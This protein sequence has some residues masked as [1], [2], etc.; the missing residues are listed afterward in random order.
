[1]EGWKLQHEAAWI[2]FAALHG[3]LEKTKK[4]LP[5]ATEEQLNNSK[6]QT[7]LIHAV[8]GNHLD[9]V[10]ELLTCDKLDINAVDLNG[11]TALHWAASVAGNKNAVQ[12]LLDAGSDIHKASADGS[13][14]LLYACS[15]GQAAI[16]RL[17]VEHGA[18]L[19]DRA[20]DNEVG[21]HLACKRGH[22][23]VVRA[24][25]ELDPEQAIHHNASGVTPMHM[26]VRAD[27]PDIVEAILE[28]SPEFV[29]IT[30]CDPQPDCTPLLLSVVDGHPKVTQV[31]LKYQADCNITKG[32]ASALQMACANRNKELVSLLL[33]SADIDINLADNDGDTPLH[34]TT[35]AL[36]HALDG[37]SVLEIA[38][39][40]IAAGA[41]IKHT[42]LNGQVAFDLAPT[43]MV[44]LLQTAAEARERPRTLMK[45]VQSAEDLRKACEKGDLEAVEQ[46]LP[47][48]TAEEI[49]AGQLTSPLHTAVVCK[50]T[51]IVKALLESKKCNVDS[52]KAASKASALHMAVVAESTEIVKLL[53]EHG[54]SPGLKDENRLTPLHI[55]SHN[56][57]VNIVKLLLEQDKLDV[58]DVDSGESTALHRACAKGHAEVVSALLEAPHLETAS[59]DRL[60]FTPLQHAA[61]HASVDCI[62]ALLTNDY[63]KHAIDKPKPD[64]FTAL[65]LAAFNKC[66]EGCK[67]LLE[68]GAEIALTNNKGQT[69]LHLAVK[70][71]A[72][73]TADVLLQHCTPEV[74]NV[75]NHKGKTALHQ[76]VKLMHGGAVSQQ[77]LFLAAV[78]G[79]APTVSHSAAHLVRDLATKLVNGGASITASDMHEN[80]PLDICPDAAF[81]SELKQAAIEF[82]KAHPEVAATLLDGSFSGKPT[83]AED[84]AKDICIKCQK[85]SPT[86]LFLPCAHMVLCSGCGS[87]TK[88]CPVCSTTVSSKIKP[89]QRSSVLSNT[90]L[91]PPEGS[92][93]EF[94]LEKEDDV[95]SRSGSLSAMA[96]SES[97][98]G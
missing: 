69:A 49:N 78:T 1:M 83:T 33:S 38:L 4:L 55:A 24:L 22:L 21:M 30:S 62:Q 6:L 23:D 56:G 97:F 85:S 11:Q 77:A 32:G 93:Y 46:L 20:E 52:Q 61:M 51:E 75:A 95:L 59:V 16:L 80:T 5:T 35:N 82:Q 42:N 65:H 71:R 39:E 43:V 31:L 25:M 27:K 41:D 73:S 90:P 48:L 79:R 40:L 50:Q 92:A 45:T 13:T 9:V 53:L 86:L 60:G 12:I 18:C 98:S 10:K 66:A 88:E 57:F 81:A 8:R 64:G 70:A 44:P 34:E 36:R 3:D 89:I 54:A 37:Q 63:V 67:L 87:E 15:F 7:P 58:N 74:L 96:R 26:A 91:A 2:H 47:Q 94:A 28:M 29:N 76:A 72:F 19:Q 68:N 84:A 17:L 14:A